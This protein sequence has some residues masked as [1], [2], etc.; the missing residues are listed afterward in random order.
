MRRQRT[1]FQTKEQDKT[2][3]N[4][5]NEMEI[6]NISNKEF[7]LMIIRVLNE[8]GRRMDEQNFNKEIEIIRSKQN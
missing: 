5:L 8:L 7:K 3:E 6:C 4:E 2:S 1:I